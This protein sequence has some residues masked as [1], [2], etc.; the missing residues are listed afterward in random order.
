MQGLRGRIAATTMRIEAAAQESEAVDL[1]PFG[2]LV[3][4]ILPD[5]FSGTAIGLT[6]AISPDGPFVPVYHEGT[7]YSIPVAAGRYVAID[8]AVLCGV[9]FVK[10]VS[11]VAEEEARSL[12]VIG[13]DFA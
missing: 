5:D 7:D 8:P 2:Q 4:I 6:A 10:V 3:G 1:R 11:N 13:R 12:M 9:P